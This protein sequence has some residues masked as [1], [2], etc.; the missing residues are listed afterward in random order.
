[1]ARAAA[2]K[3]APR[4]FHQS[5][6]RRGLGRDRERARLDAAGVEQVTDEAAHVIGLLGDE[7]VELARLGR[8][9][10]R[11]LLQQ[12]RRRALDGGERPAELMAHQGQE[13]GPQP[14]D[15][16]ERGEVLNGHHHRTN[17]AP[18]GRDRGGVDE[19]PDAAPVR[20]SEH[21]LLGAHRLGA[22]ELLRD[23]ELAQ[24]HLAP[25]GA[26]E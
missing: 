19:R 18:V 16:V 5:D 25:V 10:R 12:R 6:D 9:E 7:A 20:H 15:L 2:Q 21:H 14:L 3:R 24:R 22:A 11:R 26:A 8:V 23:G 4:V 17:G 1:M 13:L